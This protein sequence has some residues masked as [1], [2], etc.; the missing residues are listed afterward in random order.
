MGT[1]MVGAFQAGHV[2]AAHCQGFAGKEAADYH[3]RLSI[4]THEDYSHCFLLEK[5]KCNIRTDFSS[6]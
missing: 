6:W 1:K 5:T 2:L 3:R 4:D